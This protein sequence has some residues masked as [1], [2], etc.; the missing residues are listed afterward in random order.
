M[1]TASSRNPEPATGGRGGAGGR[2]GKKDVEVRYW[3]PCLGVGLGELGVE[4]EGGE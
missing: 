3:F 4:V 2:G 1:A